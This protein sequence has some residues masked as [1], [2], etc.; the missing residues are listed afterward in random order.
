MDDIRGIAKTTLCLAQVVQDFLPE[1]IQKIVCFANTINQLK[2]DYD[3]YKKFVDAFNKSLVAILKTLELNQFHENY[4]AAKKYVK[5]YIEIIKN[6]KEALKSHKITK[7]ITNAFRSANEVDDLK[8]MDECYDKIKD[9]IP[10]MS[11]YDILS[12]IPD[13]KAASFWVRYINENENEIGYDDFKNKFNSCPATKCIY[14]TL[15]DNHKPEDPSIITRQQFS[16]VVSWLGGWGKF[17]EY[18]K[19][20][21]PFT[22]EFFRHASKYIKP[23]LDVKVEVVDS[24]RVKIEPSATFHYTEYGSESTRLKHFVCYMNNGKFYSQDL[25]SDGNV[26]SGLDPKTKYKFYVYNV[27]EKLGVISDS[28]FGVSVD[29]D[30]YDKLCERIKLY[31]AE[32]ADAR[33]CMVQKIEDSLCMPKA[34][35]TWIPRCV[36][37]VPVLPTQC[38]PIFANSTSVPWFF[39]YST[40]DENT[41]NFVK[42]LRPTLVVTDAAYSLA[43]KLGYFF[44]PEV[45]FWLWKRPESIKKS[46]FMRMF[47]GNDKIGEESEDFVYHTILKYNYKH[48]ELVEKKFNWLEWTPEYD[49]KKYEKA[50]KTFTLLAQKEFVEKIEQNC[51]NFSKELCSVVMEYLGNKDI[52]KAFEVGTQSNIQGYYGPPCISE[53]AGSQSSKIIVFK[54]SVL[55]HP[56]TYTTHFP[57]KSG[58]ASEYFQTEFNKY[59]IRLTNSNFYDIL[60]SHINKIGGRSLWTMVG[61]SNCLPAVF[62][63]GQVPF[64]LVEKTFSNS[65]CTTNVLVDEIFTWMT[66]DPPSVPCIGTTFSTP[67]SVMCPMMFKSGIEFYAFGDFCLELRAKPNGSASWV[68]RSEKGSLSVEK[69]GKK[70]Q[71]VGSLV[72]EKYSEVAYIGYKLKCENKKLVLCSSG[73]ALFKVELESKTIIST[74]TLLFFVG[75]PKPTSIANLHNF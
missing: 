71:C 4:E 40:Y 36:L 46:P 15:E 27:S 50:L 65:A 61:D 3:R 39:D 23:P 56:N 55:G 41:L 38:S 52:M 8:K 45:L 63:P 13:S 17:I 22:R 58:K 74:E 1:D 33:F 60:A 5:E 35:K 6:H 28:C 72:P 24:N 19:T 75:G 30:Q 31:S 69:D 12:D 29:M 54:Q 11:S 10:L 57:V 73:C 44:S 20:K 2:E 53:L 26:I 59:A 49:E 67:C 62:M 48:N 32:N 64:S 43:E 68:I 42:S 18:A 51:E 66:N 9:L 16:Y 34:S 47:F 70:A 7:K 21:N 14:Q 37:D 25:T